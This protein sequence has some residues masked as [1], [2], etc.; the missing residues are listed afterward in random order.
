MAAPTIPVP[1]LPV[2]GPDPDLRDG[3]EFLRG[4]RF[5]DAE[6]RFRSAMARFG[7][8]PDILHYLAVCVANRGDAAAAEKLWRKAI[9]RDPD[10]AMLHFNLGVVQHR[11]GKLDEA[12]KTWRQTLRLDSDHHEARLRLAATLT[13][14]E[15]HGE[16]ETAYRDLVAAL[17]EAPDSD[18]APEAVAQRWR[19]RAMAQAGLGYVL[20]RLERPAEALEPFNAAVAD[21]PATAPEWPGI[22]ADRGLALAAAGR[23]EDS[24]AAI[25]EALAVAPD[26]ALLHH[27]RGHVLFHAGRG[28]EAIPSLQR[29]IELDASRADSAR[30]L[31]LAREREGDTAGA[32]EAFDTALKAKPGFNEAVH[33]ATSLA[34]D[35]GEFSRALDLLKP[36]LETHRDDAKAWNNAGIAFLMLGELERAHAAFKRAHRL[37]PDDPLVLTNYGRTL[38]RM[39]RPHEAAPLHRKALEL[40]PA[41]RG[42]WVTTATACWRADTRTTPAGFTKARS[43]STPTTLT[44]APASPA[45]K[46]CR[47]RRLRRRMHRE[48]FMVSAGRRFASCRVE[49]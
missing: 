39:N 24:L 3:M 45:C 6:V 7:E 31:G 25:D 27:S 1:T 40:L 33:D 8:R 34:I 17:D 47:G 13:E 49:P 21:M 16:A 12:V 20:F 35:R 32:L 37:T 30:L 9:K 10:E 4:G 2:G 14:L 48:R 28:A 42:C 18:A 46:R 38:T 41:T 43:S 15:R 5:T 23:V 36:W 19:Q 29:A 26:R 44:P 11:Q 22:Q